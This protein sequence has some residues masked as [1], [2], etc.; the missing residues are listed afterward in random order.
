MPVT[1]E[2]PTPVERERIGKGGYC[3][4]FNASVEIGH[5]RRITSELRAATACPW[6]A[7]TISESDPTTMT[8]SK[9]TINYETNPYRT[10]KKENTSIS[11]VNSLLSEDECQQIINTSEE[12][13]F[14]TRGTITADM[15]GPL[16]ELGYQLKSLNQNAGNSIIYFF[17]EGIRKLIWRRLLSTGVI[18][19][20]AATKTN[21]TTN[22]DL[23]TC[24][25][26]HYKPVGI[27]PLLRIL[28]YDKDGAFTPHQDTVY[29]VKS[30]NNQA[31]NRHGDSGQF[32]SRHTVAIYLNAQGEQF[33]GGALK[34]VNQD[35]VTFD[36]NNK[37][38]VHYPEHSPKVEVSPEA[39]KAVIFEHRE[40]HEG[41]VVT[42][43]VKYMLQTDIVYKFIPAEE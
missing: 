8:V 32:L 29:L 12:A 26:G 24:L 35:R 39:G 14:I 43:G 6:K 4:I 7:I 30:F 40:W 1:F 37:P 33:E 34:F 13:G 36:E 10:K 21:C 20:E 2:T 18:D 25:S 16:S 17:D 9:K 38:I 11:I 28:K 27:H 19:T 5:P 23:C 41:A 22:V 3:K 31:T 42:S 15:F